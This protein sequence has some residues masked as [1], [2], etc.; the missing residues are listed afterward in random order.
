MKTTLALSGL[1]A[2]LAGAS[3][4]HAA[5]TLVSPGLPTVENTAGAC[6][7]RNV[8][9]NPIA[10]HVSAI[11]NFVPGSIDPDFQ[12]CNDAPLAPGRTCVLLENTLPADVTFECAA[13]VS[14]NPKN[15]RATAELRRILPNGVAVIAAQDL[16]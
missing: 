13:E 1:A 12:N 10:L 11:Q 14:G 9:T 5:R 4:A 6:Y 8:G 2:L 15:L 7:F 3:L 16:Q